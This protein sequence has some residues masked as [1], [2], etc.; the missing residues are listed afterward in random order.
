MGIVVQSHLNN[1]YSEILGGSTFGGESDYASWIRPNL[2]LI[3]GSGSVGSLPGGTA[4]EGQE[5]PWM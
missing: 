3:P 4:G 5:H 1:H 2:R